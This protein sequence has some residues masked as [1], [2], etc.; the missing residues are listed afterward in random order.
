MLANKSCGFRAYLLHIAL[1]QSYSVLSILILVSHTM[2]YCF[3]DYPLLKQHRANLG[4]IIHPP[5]PPIIEVS[6]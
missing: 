2:Y 4:G 3:Y 6:L 1:T 5:S